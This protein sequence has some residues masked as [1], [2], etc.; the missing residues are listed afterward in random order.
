[1]ISKVL[2]E[3]N[4]NCAKTFASLRLYG[5]SLEPKEVSRLLQLDPDDSAPKGLKTTVSGKSRTAPTG[6]WILR[7]E[8]RIE[9]TNLEDH[10]EWLVDHLEKAGVS[11]I[12]IEGV[13]AADLFCF[14]DSATGHG[15]PKF[16][17]ELLNRLAKLQLSLG[18]DIYFSAANK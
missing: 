18:L 12:H 17:P 3:A 5:D 10:I 15:G 7:T 14:W 8:G 9:S 16:S 13:T 6:R 11:P 1:M 2:R 4:P